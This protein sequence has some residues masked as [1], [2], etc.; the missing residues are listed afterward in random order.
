MFYHINVNDAKYFNFPFKKV[1]KEHKYKENKFN[2]QIV[3]KSIHGKY[4]L[5]FKGMDGWKFFNKIKTTNYLKKSKFYPKTHIIND[6]EELKTVKLDKKKFFFVK[7]KF[8][9]SSRK[10]VY[11]DKERNPLFGDLESMIYPAIVQEE[12]KSERRDGKK[13]DYRIFVLYIRNGNEVKGFFYEDGVVR[14]TKSMEKIVN[15]EENKEDLIREIKNFRGDENLLECLKDINERVVKKLP[16]ENKTDLEFFL[17]GFDIIK[18][19]D[20]KYW[21]T[22][23]NATPRLQ[24]N[25]FFP[26]ARLINNMLE[27]I[28]NIITKYEEDEAIFIDKFIEL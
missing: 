9:D 11:I 24:F 17:T 26:L 20:K 2:P 5:N 4:S 1:L 19:K 8:G 7:S 3:S 27:E 16:N 14:Y 15:N 10:V 6:A 28:H 25:D 18:D 22:E 13:L 23:I 12:V 21:V